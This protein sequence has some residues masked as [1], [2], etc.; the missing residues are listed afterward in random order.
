MNQDDKLLQILKGS[1]C[2][3]RRQMIDYLQGKLFPEELYVVELHLNECPFC[4][5]AIAGYANS[6]ANIE[7]LVSA[8]IPDLTLSNNLQDK[9]TRS[10]EKVNPTPKVTTIETVE[11]PKNNHEKKE[12]LPS[13]KGS[14]HFLDKKFSASANYD[15]IDQLAHKKKTKDPSK[16]TIENNSNFK[17]KIVR[18]GLI[19]SILVIGIGVYAYNKYSDYYT[20]SEQA[21]YLLPEEE[22]EQKEDVV[23]SIIDEDISDP[24]DSFFNEKYGD[25]EYDSRPELS[26]LAKNNAPKEIKKTTTEVP[27]VKNET[28]A[29]QENT[30]V[31]T[32]PT[33]EKKTTVN[34]PINKEIA[35]TTVKEVKD[36]SKNKPV[37]KVVKTTSE[38]DKN[39]DKSKNPSTT[40][41]AST[42]PK[43]ETKDVKA[44][45]VKDDKTAT[46]PKP[47]YTYNGS[48]TANKE[49]KE[50]KETPK[51]KP[52]G[53]TAQKSNS[54]TA[55]NSGSSDFDNGMEAFNK[56]KYAIA[57]MYF[58]TDK[59][60]ASSKKHYQ[61]LYQTA[62]SHKNLNQ[63]TKAK[64]ILE[65]LVKENAPNKSAAQ[66]LLDNL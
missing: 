23:E 41:I 29:N 53:T 57:I 20:K 61:A 1:A 22:S 15:E 24:K 51:E 28:P 64:Q 58:S 33:E 40:T 6:K 16:N 32:N 48:T 30:L 45:E 65:K 55:N 14:S 19:I 12:D 17:R 2:I 7:L 63:T 49:T 31:P 35:K 39:K 50:V 52:A 25:K 10:S 18:N 9:K 8:D 13:S 3:N 54:T 47:K 66:K 56:G 46:T 60:N 43:K 59:N 26:S 11:P 27:I 44:N 38:T 5:D 62:V 21:S 36:S 37:E 42:T 4:N 34:E